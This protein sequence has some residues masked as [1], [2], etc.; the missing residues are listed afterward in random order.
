MFYVVVYVYVVCDVVGFDIGFVVVECDEL[1][2]YVMLG[3][4]VMFDYV[5]V[6]D[7]CIVVV[8]VEVGVG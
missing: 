6:G 4:V 2:V 5:Y 7:D 8:E 1:V 3:C